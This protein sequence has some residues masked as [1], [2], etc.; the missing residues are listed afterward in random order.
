ITDALDMKGVTKYFPP[1][2][3]ELNALKAGNDILLLPQDLGLAVRTLHS[4]ID[5]GL[6]PME[7]I[8]QKCRKILELKY[9]VGLQEVPSID[10]AHLF[11]DLNP[12]SS[13]ALTR[14]IYREAVTLDRNENHLLPL[15]LLEYRK[16][17]VLSVGDSNPTAFQ[18][19]IGKYAEAS[20]FSLPADFRPP[21]RDSLL[22]KLQPYN[23]LIIGIHN[24][25]SLPGKNFGLTVQ[26][27]ALVDTLA[28]LKKTVLDI[29]GSPYILGMLKSPP[30][31][32]AI[33]VSYQ[34]VPASGDISAQAI[35]GGTPFAG[36]L[37]VTGSVSFPLHAGLET[38]VT[39]LSCAMPEEL[40]ISSSDLSR[41]DTLALAGVKARAYPG[42]QILFAKDG[43]IFY[44]KSFGHP[45]YEDTL[46]VNNRMI[47]DLASL[48]K[49]FAT[50][51]AVMKLSE[52]G[53]LSPDSTLGTYLPEARG[54]NKQKL[55]IRS[56]MAHQA[57]LQDW[58]RF[59]ERTLKN[60][61]P[62]PE[63]YRPDSSAEFPVRV[64]EGLFIRKDYPDTLLKA[65][66]DSPLRP[67]H[68]YKYS[69]LGFYLLKIIVERL[70]GQPFD[71]FLDGQFYRPLGL[72]RT[73][74]LPWMYFPRSE[75]MPTEND[76]HFRHRQLRGDVHDPGAAML[77]GISGHAGLF[78]DAGDLAVMLQML[79]NGGSYGGKQ[80]LLPSTIREFTRV[81]FPGNGNRRGLG[82][83]KPAAVYVPDGPVCQGASPES[84][85]HSGFTGTYC[86]ADPADKLIYIFL[87]NRVYPDS[88]NNRISEMNIRTRIHQ[89]MYDILGSGRK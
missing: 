76:T 31:A 85:G 46:T 68:D 86:W 81:Q 11:A 51:L 66:L 30:S 84:F 41:I 62:D 40:G 28:R 44:Q 10:T 60:G 89:A 2:I 1:G 69:D 24:T 33:L 73:T 63:I 8:D 59:Y 65:I 80:Y 87:S 22:K 21:V 29:F 35:F 55:T 19:S 70:T 50:T 42:C 58:I 52:D 74:F 15:G 6:I 67:S 57:G 48:T 23:L 5:S 25:S 75:I 13:E 37:P 72:Q 88:G 49:I 45:R 38:S 16:I 36:R 56:I 7:L 77:G 27:V 34:D 43:K 14:K 61:V 32:E 12:V 20:C 17:A 64:C 71:Q 39:R 79:L 78:S 4:A 54:T 18:Q 3:L 26:E 82:F 53:K 9:R 83:D 47:Y